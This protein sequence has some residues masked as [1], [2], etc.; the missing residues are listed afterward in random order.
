MTNP[1]DPPRKL[2]LGW[3][4]ALAIATILLTM[5]GGWFVLKYRVDI[6]E[7]SQEALASQVRLDHDKLVIIQND[8]G[9]LKDDFGEFKYEQK[10]QRGL[11]EDIRQEIRR[12]NGR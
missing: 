1:I 7:A 5:G 12:V 4:F 10:E 8:V 9:H 11:L 6:V 2:V 3:K